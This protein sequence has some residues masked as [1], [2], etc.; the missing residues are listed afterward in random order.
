MSAPFLRDAD[1]GCTLSVRVH[2]GAK[3]NA[4]TGTHDG[5][6]KIALTAPPADGRAN[7]ALVSFVAERLGVPRASISLLTGATSR[8]K[9]LR[10]LGLTSVEAEEKLLPGLA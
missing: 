5:A 4:V 3:R 7:A 9:T 6:L 1:G 10:I 2:P 8:S